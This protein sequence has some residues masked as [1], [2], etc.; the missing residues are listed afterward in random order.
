[1]ELVI[2]GV[3][4]IQAGSNPR[5]VAQRLRSLLPEADR[6]LEAKAA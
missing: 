2:E 4:A 6:D 5:V 3:M 1:M